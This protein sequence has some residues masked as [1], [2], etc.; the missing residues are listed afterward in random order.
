MALNKFPG[1]RLAGWDVN[2]SNEEKLGKLLFLESLG[3]KTVKEKIMITSTESQ[4][5]SNG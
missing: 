3:F 4:P 5:E 1:R 2:A